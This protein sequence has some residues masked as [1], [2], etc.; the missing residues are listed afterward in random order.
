MAG[1]K[2]VKYDHDTEDCRRMAISHARNEKELFNLSHK[3]NN[4]YKKAK[5]KPEVGSGC[6]HIHNH[7]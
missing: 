1:N 5:E 7:N 3:G 2:V 6:K 4:R